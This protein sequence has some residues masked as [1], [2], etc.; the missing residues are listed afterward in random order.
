MAWGY[1]FKLTYGPIFN[2]PKK[3]HLSV[4]ENKSIEKQCVGKHDS[5][6]KVL[7]RD[8]LLTLYASA[9][10]NMSTPLCLQT[11]IFF[12]IEILTAIRPSAVEALTRT[13]FKKMTIRGKMFGVIT[14]EICSELGAS[15]T[16]RGGWSS[17]EEKL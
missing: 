9:S 3:D 10:I 6:Q 16:S 1:D 17:I 13:Q 5:S 15:K 12:I 2:C 8:D 4:V 7:Y 11:I 14:V